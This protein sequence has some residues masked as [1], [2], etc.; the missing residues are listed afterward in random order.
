MLVRTHLAKL[1]HHHNRGS[2]IELRVVRHLHT[3]HAYAHHRPVIASNFPWLNAKC[4]SKKSPAN[5]NGFAWLFSRRRSRSLTESTRQI[6]PPTKNGH[7]PPPIESRK[8]CQSVNP[9]YVRTWWVSPCWVKLS[10][11]LHSWWCPSVNSFKF[12]PCDHTPPGTQRLWFLIQC[13]SSPWM[14]STDPE[15][16]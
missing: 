6:T 2:F 16:A 5:P 8:S 10:R 14:F 13:Q 3:W 4:P 11:R 1:V 9:Y 12:Q 15:S 7:A